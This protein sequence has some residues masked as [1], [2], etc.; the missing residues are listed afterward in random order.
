MSNI[1]I[2]K[3]SIILWL[4]NTLNLD[5]I[6][7]EI[8]SSDAS[9][10]RYFRV[11]HQAGQQI[12]MDAPPEK[13]NIIPFI[14]IAALFSQQEIHVPEIIHQDLSQ[15]FLLLEDL[16]SDCLLDKLNANNAF[17]LY[18]SAFDSLYQIQNRIEVSRC[19]LPYYDE[20]L[21]ERELAIFYQW[22]LSQTLKLSIPD[23]VTST[24]NQ[25]LITSAIEQPQVCVHRDFHCRNLMLLKNN[26]LGIIDFQDAVIGP[27]TYDLVS[28]LRDCYIAWPSHD[29]EQWM[30]SYFDRLINAGLL[31]CSLQTFTRWFDLMGLQRHLKAIGIFSRL[32]LRDK[33]SC[34]LNDIPRTLNYVIQICKK[35]PELEPFNH[36]LTQ[37]ILPTY[38]ST[39]NTKP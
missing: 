17:K 37:T 21:L 11:I 25:V 15:G 20:A 6:H 14:T 10:R 27:I 9:F 34:Y 38:H 1:D 7:F 32:H 13:E 31:N 22:F 36:Y 12:V 33:K 4:E 3:Q 23:S 18:S 2:R 26:S 5:I 35:Y 30:S 8:A 24:F 29:I 16:G 19:Q 28:L 39:L